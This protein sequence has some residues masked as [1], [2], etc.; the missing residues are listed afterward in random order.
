MSVCRTSGCVNP[1][2]ERARRRSASTVFPVWLALFDQSAQAFLRVFEM[3]ELVEKNTHG[4]LETV[5]KRETHSAENGSLGHGQHGSGMRGD[6]RDQ[7]VDAFLQL[8]L[9]AQAS[10]QAEFEGPLGGYGFAGEDEFE[11]GL[12]SDK[13]R[14][15]CGGQRRKEADGNLR[16]GEARPQGSDVDE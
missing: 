12:G 16:L 15:D 7:V 11:S 8:R 5:A 10:H 3:V 9:G 6:A 2:P 1:P 14:E 4:L 13:K